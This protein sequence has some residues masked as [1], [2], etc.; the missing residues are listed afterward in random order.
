MADTAVL[1]VDVASADFDKFKATFDQYAKTLEQTLAT[2]KKITDEVKAAS[3]VMSNIAAPVA[4]STASLQKFTATFAESAKHTKTIR[5]D[6]EGIAKGLVSWRT[7]MTSTLALLGLGGGLFGLT[8]LV[9]GSIADRARALAAGVSYGQFRGMNVGAFP[10]AGA[11][12]QGFGTARWD[13][14]S[15]A[16]RGANVLFGSQADQQLQRT[17]P[18]V[19]IDAL[20]KAT[21]Y[22]GQFD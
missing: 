4:K 14:T 10:G 18:L 1:R 15:N 3:A 2:W 5:S 7:A 8:S 13:P 22:L 20:D 19:M 21:R 6:V 17:D 16:Y 9:Q 11:A 12:M